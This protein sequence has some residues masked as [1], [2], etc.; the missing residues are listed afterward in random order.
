MLAARCGRGT[1]DGLAARPW[2]QVIDD[3]RLVMIRAAATHEVRDAWSRQGSVVRQS[4]FMGPR[5]L[6]AVRRCACL[7]EAGQVLPEQAGLGVPDAAQG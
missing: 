5:L 7:S 6:R 4:S 1:L 2:V 3:G